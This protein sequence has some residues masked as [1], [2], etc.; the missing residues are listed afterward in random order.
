MDWVTYIL[1]IGSVGLVTFGMVFLLFAE[2]FKGW[3]QQEDD[4]ARS[5]KISAYSVT[6]KERLALSP[7]PA[8]KAILSRFSEVFRRRTLVLEEESTSE[9]DDSQRPPSRASRP[10]F[11]S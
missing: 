11:H 5:S 3:R 6:E 4:S 10:Q 8:S 2:M 7:L 9:N 1:I